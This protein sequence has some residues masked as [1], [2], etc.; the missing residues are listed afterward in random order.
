M[1]RFGYPGN[2]HNATIPKRRDVVVNVLAPTVPY[3]D[4]T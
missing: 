1:P 4:S 3:N 2:F